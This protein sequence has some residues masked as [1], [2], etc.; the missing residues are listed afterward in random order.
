MAGWEGGAEAYRRSFA[1]L[2]AGS[3]ETLLEAT[4]P[5]HDHLDVGCGTGDLSLAAVRRGRRV[6]A[7]DP[8]PEMASMTRAAATRDGLALEVLEAGAPGLPLADASVGAVTANFVL[9]HVPA[10]RAAMRDIARVAAPSAP[11]AMTIWPAV[12]GPHLDAY[13]EAARAAGAV[14]VAS[15]RLA[16]ELD[17]PRTAD[18]LAG[19]ARQA[20]LT[21]TRAEEL[22][23]TWTV[24]A[25]DLLAGIRG[26][27]AGPGRIHRAQTPAVRAEIETRARALWK[28]FETEP[29]LLLFPVT[30]ALVVASRP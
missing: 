25:E 10:P 13:G 7:V 19:L 11:L 14:P 24:T 8:D 23:W 27:V 16:P 30:A 12:P 20:G 29:G 21:V 5:A 6:T 3:I 4:E 15:T 28:A 2:C 17:F 1:T 18:G 26:G 22:H 9:N